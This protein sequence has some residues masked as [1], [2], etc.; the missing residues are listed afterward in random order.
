MTN[1]KNVHGTVSDTTKP[2]WATP[3]VDVLNVSE[4]QNSGAV[5]ADPSVSLGPAAS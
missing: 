4:T 3:V 2:V 1:D 5:R